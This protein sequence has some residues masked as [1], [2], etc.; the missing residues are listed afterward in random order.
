MNNY[1]RSK[2][3]TNVGWNAV[4]G[5]LFSLPFIIGFLFFYISPIIT[6]IVMAFSKLSLNDMGNMQFTSVGWD[7]F[8]EAIFVQDDYLIN[9]FSNLGDLLIMFPSVLLFSF[10]IAMLLNQKFHGR[11]FAR[12]LYFLPVIIASGVTAVNQSD[13]L[14]GAAVSAVTGVSGSVDGTVNLT[15]IITNLFASSMNSTFFSLVETLVSKI[16]NITMASG[17]QI[18]IFLAGLQSISPSLYEAS[19]I[20]GATAWEN[21]WKI[22]LPMISP[23]I[24]VNAVYT[25]VDIL[26]STQNSLIN[27]LYS[28]SIEGME[29][30]LSSAMGVLYFG[31]TFIIVGI[32][33]FFMSRMVFY[34]ER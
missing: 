22:T 20:E 27:D 19:S 9:I 3:L 14:T 12:V 21:F 1:F 8:Y 24:L 26:G 30:G 15:G 33:I 4:A 6:Y 29:Y 25:I 13:A 5:L 34:E 28:L 17:V 7:N 10:F 23:M 11:T 31:I 32:V 2:K 16:Y 18:L